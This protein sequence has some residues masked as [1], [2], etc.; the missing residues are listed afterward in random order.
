MSLPFD[1]AKSMKSE[2][3]LYTYKDV[4]E[5]VAFALIKDKAEG[6]T[7]ESFQTKYPDVFDLKIIEAHRLISYS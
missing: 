7:I 5:L 4:I 6:E 1:I 3:R 2:T